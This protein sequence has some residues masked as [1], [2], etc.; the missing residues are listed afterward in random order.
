ML[1]CRHAPDRAQGLSSQVLQFP[2][3][4]IGFCGGNFKGESAHNFLTSYQPEELIF[5]SYLQGV[6]M[7]W[8]VS[9]VCFLKSGCSKTKLVVVKTLIRKMVLCKEDML[10]DLFSLHYAF[11]LVPILCTLCLIV[12]RNRMKGTKVELYKALAITSDLY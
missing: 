6:Y 2:Q 1:G 8:F 5:W 10:I 3:D 4:L 9:V 12:S 7:L 11:E